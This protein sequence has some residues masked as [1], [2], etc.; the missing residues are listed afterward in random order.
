M[1]P[2]VSA[3]IPHLALRYITSVASRTTATTIAAAV[4]VEGPDRRSGIPHPEE[5]LSIPSSIHEN[6]CLGHHS[7]RRIAF[8]RFPRY[9]SSSRKDPGMSDIILLYSEYGTA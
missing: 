2:G 7:T 4:S 3:E 8:S 5:A 6:R 9:F 1:I